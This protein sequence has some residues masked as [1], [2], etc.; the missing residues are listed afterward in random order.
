MVQYVQ[1]ENLKQRI[2]DRV[3]KTETKHEKEEE[4]EEVVVD[5]E[6]DDEPREPTVPAPTRSDMECQTDE[7]FFTAPKPGDSSEKETPAPPEDSSEKEKSGEQ[8]PKIQSDDTA[9]EQETAKRLYYGYDI[10]GSE[11]DSVF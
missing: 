11:D 6:E 5:Y 10:T 7:S 1:C 2:L 4:V 3:V 8:E 9:P